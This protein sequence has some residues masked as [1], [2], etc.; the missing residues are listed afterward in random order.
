M[1]HLRL[2]GCALAFAVLWSCGSTTLYK[3]TSPG[4]NNELVFELSEKGEPMYR[5]SSDG[6][7]VLKPSLLGFE[8]QGLA[9][10]TENFEVVA[11]DKRHSD[12]T[13]EQPWGE[14]KKVRDNHNEL[15]IHL[16][17]KSGD[18][19]LVDV[20]F[21]VFD[22]GMGFRY[23][24]PKQ[25]KLDKVKISN[26]VTQFVFPANEDVWWIPVHRENS[27]LESYYRKTPMSK[28]DTIN[29]PAT[30]E[31]KSKLFVAVHE[32][33]LTDFASM[34]L[35]N[36]GNNTYKSDLVPWADGVKVYAQTPFKTPWRTVIVAQNPGDLATSPLMLNLN[37]PSKIE[38]LSWITPSKYIG[39]WW[40]M[41]LEKYTWGQGE[42][43]GATTENVKRH[44]D[45]ASENGFNGVLVEGWNQGWDGDWTA[46]GKAFSFVKAYADFDLEAITKYAAMKNVRL[47]GH[48]E[49]AGAA[50]HYESQLEDAFRLYNKVGVNSVKTGYVNK[51]LDKKEWHDGQFGVRHYR[52]VVETAAKFHIMIDNHE[53]VKG[54]GISRT[55][56]N[57]MTQEGGR[58][59][60]YDA[61]SSDGGNN[62][63]HTTILPFTRMLSAPMD[64][65]PGTFNFDYK[66]PAGAKVQTTLAK[67]L[68]LYVVLFS[69]LQMASDL[70]ENYVGKPEFQFIKDVPEVWSHT[71][72]L[73][74]KIGEYVNIARKDWNSENWYLGSITNSEARKTTL[75]LDFLD[76]DKTYAAEIYEDGTGADYKSNPYPVK[77]SKKA[78]TKDDTL[79]L[80]LAPG[81][82]TAVRFVPKP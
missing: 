51:Y 81:G 43:H 31:T 60:E 9:K 61:W 58:G 77:I 22:D 55:Y 41:H 52:K 75:K 80:N 24:F 14:T 73:D 59:Q 3:V 33:N 44:I 20:V 5:F 27:Y 29:T 23:E 78:F 56:P 53:P 79:E 49:T 12:T 21:R 70:P 2:I 64:F 38:D 72:Y 65:T 46:D 7:V 50:S 39:I 4:K 57:L 68:A 1:R 30:F 16:K 71:K 45:F 32:A 26:E 13:W 36:S 37:E 47:I 63:E 11:T 18:Q 8:F 6:K 15:T 62:P 69:P 10:M 25:P 40:G 19:R 54:T 42:K 28:T 35:L 82:G 34:T 76:K 17:E 67:Q 48:H 74:S 66:T